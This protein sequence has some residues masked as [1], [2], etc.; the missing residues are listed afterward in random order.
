MKLTKGKKFSKNSWQ[1]LINDLPVDKKHKEQLLNL[2]PHT[3]IG[4]SEK[5]V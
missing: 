4:L 1:K 5:L 3:Y 2:T